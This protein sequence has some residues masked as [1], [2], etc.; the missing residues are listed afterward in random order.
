MSHL[1]RV[2]RQA[3]PVGRQGCA[4]SGQDRLGGGKTGAETGR[5]S[6]QGLAGARSRRCWATRSTKC[7][8]RLATDRFAG[9]SWWWTNTRSVPILE[10]LLR[11]AGQ[12]V[13]MSK[14]LSG[15]E[16]P[17]SAGRSSEETR[18]MP[19]A[20]VT[21]PICCSSRRVLAEGGQLEDPASFV[22]R[23]NGLLLAMG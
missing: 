1:E 21:G 12:N 6:V 9:L 13:P 3:F 20:S 11:D 23:L 10:R 17:A 4:G 18:V 15:A 22:K 2:R 7:G 8:F 19:A 14:P 5:G 16:S